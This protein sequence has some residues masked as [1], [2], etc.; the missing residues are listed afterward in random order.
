MRPPLPIGA[1]GEISAA[2][3]SSG[4]WRARA[5]YRDSTGVRRDVTATAPTKASAITG[6]KEKILSFQVANEVSPQMRLGDFVQMWVADYEPTVTANTMRVTRLVLKNFIV[7]VGQMRLN[8]V[9][10]PWLERQIAAA[11]EKKKRGGTVTGG[12][13]TAIRLRTMYKMIFDEAVRLGALADNPAAKTRPVRREASEVKAL[14]PQQLY[15]LRRGVRAYY[16]TYP[17]WT[18]AKE[19]MPD[20]VDFLVGTG[21]RVGEAIALRWDDVNL[22]TGLCTIRATA[23]ID[24]GAS[25]YQPFTKTKHVRAVTMPGWLIESLLQRARVGEFVFQ[26]SSGGMVKYSTLRSSFAS[27]VPADLG[28]ITPKII[29]ASVATIIERELGLEAA[30]IQLGH[31]DFKTTRKSYI[32]RRGVADASEVL[33]SL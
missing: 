16:E 27:A 22:E 28:G 31:D 23:L 25:V 5:Y 13:S 29:R 14:S 1:H 24:H 15:E 33:R 19:W 10:V 7:P 20:L 6:L 9:T 3:T 4:K 8:E 17:Y 2:K 11:G 26:S 32:E 21:C 30:G 18:R 12:V